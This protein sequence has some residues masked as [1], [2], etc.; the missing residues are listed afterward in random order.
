[1]RQAFVSALMK[2]A[3]TQPR[4]VLLTGDLGFRVLEPFAQEF[5]DRYINV[6]VAESNLVTMAAGLAA[7]GYI[8]VVYSIATFM[9]MRPFE[10]IRNDVSLQNLG[11]KIVGVG[12]GLA[13][14]PAGP[15]H[16]SI[17]DIAL[18]RTLPNMAI[19]V[20][21][22]KNEAYAATTA[23]LRWAGP[24]YL[25]IERNPSA[26]VYM[27]P[28]S[29]EVGKARTVRRGKDCALLA[30]GTEVETALA[31]RTILQS[32]DIDASVIAF[33]TISP[34]DVAMVRRL[35]RRFDI[36]VTIEEH[37][38]DGGFGSAILETQSEYGGSRVRVLRFGLTKEY[39]RGS[40]H[41]NVLRSKY[42]LTAEA[43][44]SRVRLIHSRR[45]KS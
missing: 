16:H 18:M 45:T 22:D 8:P 21:A 32:H 29:F 4:I 14:G 23:A 12:G 2:Q 25:R 19:V 41:Y 10:F 33:P 28:V 17:E 9:S 13:Y 39:V 31:V 44:A 15:T 11:V 27:S 3:R 40:A 36:I 38:K 7:D 34:L 6:G 1:M 30:T 43:I 26:D 35:T 42:G 37:L 20:P 5:P 24:V